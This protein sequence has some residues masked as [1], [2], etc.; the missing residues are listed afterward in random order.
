MYY[1]PSFAYLSVIWVTNY[2]SV[3]ATFWHISEQKTL[4]QEYDF[5]NSRHIFFPRHSFLLL[6]LLL[7]KKSFLV[8]F[9]S[10]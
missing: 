10:S 3:S 8:C 6:L 1:V 7:E 9:Y 2:M 5:G 4:Y